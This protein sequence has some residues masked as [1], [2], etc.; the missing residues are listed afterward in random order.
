MGEGVEQDVANARI[1]FVGI[2]DA[3]NLAPTT[4]SCVEDIIMLSDGDTFNPGLKASSRNWMK[5]PS[6]ASQRQDPAQSVARQLHDMLGG[7][8]LFFAQ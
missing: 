4:M 3:S 5:M 7:H 8:L 2:F 1:V 6:A